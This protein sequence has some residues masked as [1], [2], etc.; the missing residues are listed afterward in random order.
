M[1]ERPTLMTTQQS[2][3]TLASRG[4]KPAA[5]LAANRDHGDRLRYLGGCRCDDC[6]RANT[7]YECA[8]AKARKGGDWNGNISAAKARRHLLALSEQGIGKRA[9]QAATDI[10]TSILQGIR[11][12]TKKKIRARTERK[13]LAVTKEMASDHALIPAADTWALINKLIVEGYT[14]A[15]LAELLG[16]SN[17]ALQFRRDQITVRNAH[18]IRKLYNKLEAT[19]FADAKKRKPVE[20]LPKGTTSPKRGLLVHRMEG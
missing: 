8:R 7:A 16:Y 1:K 6:R 12:G 10:G 14:K 5:V 20:A 15:Q 13:I 4:L 19:G 17:Q 2:T 18:E 11:S 9:V 3:R